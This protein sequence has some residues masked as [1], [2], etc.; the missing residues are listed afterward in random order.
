MLSMKNQVN[1]ILRWKIKRLSMNQQDKQRKSNG[2]SQR[3]SSLTL[4]VKMQ[5]IVEADI[6][7]IMD[8]MDIIHTE[9]QRYQHSKTPRR[10]IA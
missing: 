7:D 2:Y 4:G 8:I 6:M 10:V 1:K 9:I 3:N 5:S